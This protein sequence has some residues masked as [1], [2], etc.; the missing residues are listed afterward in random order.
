FTEVGKDALPTG[1]QEIRFV[2]PSGTLTIDLPAGQYHVLVSRG[3]EYSIHP[4]T[5]PSVPGTAVDLRTG[6]RVL[7]ATL[8]K[9]VDTTGWLSAD[10]H[11]HA[12]NSPDSRINNL[13]RVLNFAGEGVDILVAT[14]HDVV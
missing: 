5:Y 14:D 8:V 10:F 13:H 9:V 11:V 4:N 2:P 3:P 7:D 6:D 12:I 1:V